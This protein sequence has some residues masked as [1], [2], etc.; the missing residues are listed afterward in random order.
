MRT[1]IHRPRLSI[2]DGFNY[3]TNEGAI[4]RFFEAVLWN[5]GGSFD[6]TRS[7]SRGVAFLDGLEKGVS[8]DVVRPSAFPWRRQ[9]HDDNPDQ[10][11]GSAAVIDQWIFIPNDLLLLPCCTGEALPW[12]L[13]QDTGPRLM[14]LWLGTYRRI[15]FHYPNSPV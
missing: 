14:L 7:Y 4:F 13:S 5:E 11:L 9:F 1:T 10:Q 2:F 12:I 3:P 6:K 8:I 15:T